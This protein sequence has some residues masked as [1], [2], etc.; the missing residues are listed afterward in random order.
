MKLNAKA[1]L[2]A[3]SAAIIE[4][5]QALKKDYVDR[6]DGLSTR[7]DALSKEFEERMSSIAEAINAPRQPE[8]ASSDKKELEEL[9]RD[10]DERFKSFSIEIE[11][12]IGDAEKRAMERGAQLIEQ[13]RQFVASI[14]PPT[15]ATELLSVMRQDRSDIQSMLDAA[16]AAVPK[17]DIEAFRKEV[18]ATVEESAQRLREEIERSS[19]Q[20]LDSFPEIPTL[21]EL[22]TI[23]SLEEIA[24]AAAALARPSV[25]EMVASVMPLLAERVEN[26]SAQ[27][28]LDFER[29]AQDWVHKFL[30]RIP[31]PKDG[32]DGVDGKDALPISELK[33]ERAGKSIRFILGDKVAEVPFMFLDWKGFYKKDA[34]YEAGDVIS[35]GGSAF[36]AERRTSKHPEEKDSGWH[37]IVRKGR[38][39][40]PGDKGDKGD[41]GEPGKVEVKNPFDPLNKV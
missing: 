36:I 23:P 34:T 31:K 27:W 26:R 18:A 20:L 37:I 40:R 9:S 33:M 17:F 2:D 15:S 30:D 21:P 5:G 22:P 1:I 10:I 4:M 24:S 11:K 3:V 39:G 28:E 35:C 8:P 13:M 41:K 38:D 32:K 29:R 14:P 12:K 7:I 16:V 6:V 25:E 19:K